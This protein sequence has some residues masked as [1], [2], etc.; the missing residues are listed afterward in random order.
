M[1]EKLNL[2]ELLFKDLLK[3]AK[4]HAD[5]KEIY[6]KEVKNIGMVTILVFLLIGI[7]WIKTAERLP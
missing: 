3:N 6:E 4:F 5:H 7:T 2:I 1:K